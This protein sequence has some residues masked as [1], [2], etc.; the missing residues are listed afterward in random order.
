MPW[1]YHET[2][3]AGSDWTAAKVD[4]L[5][6]QLAPVANAAAPGFLESP[7]VARAVGTLLRGALSDPTT[8]ASL[9]RLYAEAA[10]WLGA[11]VAG[12]LLI[13]NRLRK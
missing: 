5:A 10:L 9:R 12:G 3:A 2:G 4:A 1:I 6:A 7:A 11:G 13:Y 8:Q